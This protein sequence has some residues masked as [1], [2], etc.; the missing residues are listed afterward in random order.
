MPITNLSL[1]SDESAGGPLVWTGS[2]FASAW[3]VRAGN[4]HYDIY[5][6]QLDSNGKKLGPDTRL[7]NGNGFAVTPSVLWDGINFWIAWSD[8]IGGGTRSKFMG[9]KSR[10]MGNS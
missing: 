6:N 8:S 3:Q 5:F 7:T 2:V 4:G 1:T 9:K 10:K